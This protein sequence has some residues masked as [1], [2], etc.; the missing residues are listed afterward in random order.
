MSPNRLRP[1]VAAAVA[2]ALLAAAPGLLAQDY[3]DLPGP[4]EGVAAERLAAVLA[5]LESGE[6]AAV[7]ALLAE[8][9]TPEFRESVPPRVHLDAFASTHAR[10]HGFDLHGMR[11]YEPPRPPEHLTAIVRNR[12]TG[13]WEAVILELEPEPPHRITGLGF[14]PARP[15]SDL[16]PPPPLA[17]D[18]AMV[19]ELSALVDRLA[20]AEVFSGTVLLARDG[21]VL[22]SAARGDAHKGFGVA[23]TLDTKFNLGSMNKLFTS[24]ALAQLV[25]EGK[26][27][28]DDPLSKYVGADWLPA[29]VTEKVRLEHLL[30]H[31]SGLGSYFNE[32]FD[33]SSRALYRELDDY[34][35]LV[36]GETLAFEPGTDRRYSNTG[37]F[38]VGVVIEKVTG[39]SY[40]EH[41][42]EAVYRPAGMTDT[43]CYEMD[44]VVPDLAIGYSREADGWRNNLYRH[45]LRGGPAGGCFST[46]PDL[47]R[48]ARAVREH[49]LL[50]PEVQTEVFRPR[51]EL[52]SPRYGYGTVVEGTPE[53]RIVGH[54]GGFA[55][56]SAH[57]GI[58]LDTGYTAIVLANVDQGAEPVRQA[59][60]ELVRRR[61]AGRSGG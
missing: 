12:L 20:A 2:A 52:G 3:R 54:G 6:P 44:R 50:S 59:I 30:T 32:T 1:A 56:I 35:P 17:S 58:H 46:A 31:T 34:K 7:E 57:L 48:F 37:M 47:L 29:E 61:E 24:I 49:R 27:R 26:V 23:N 39:K 15:P 43:D 9:A 51:P 10:S 36:A 21:E 38:L 45:V 5:A 13:G 40:F 60:A 11:H 53:D 41:M 8:H 28:F 18:E 19:A 14:A 4:P 42:R 25:E 55:G 16:P 22:Y 33:R